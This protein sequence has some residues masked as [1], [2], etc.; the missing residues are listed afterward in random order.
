MFR[1]RRALVA[2]LLPEDVAR[3]REGVG[4][5][6]ARVSYP[7]VAT[8]PLVGPPH[9]VEIHDMHSKEPVWQLEVRDRSG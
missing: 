6:V 8:I 2:H 3:G 9:I 4:A 5:P 7:V 1:A